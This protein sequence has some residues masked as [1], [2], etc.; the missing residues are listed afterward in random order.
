MTGSELAR[1]LRLPSPTVNRLLSGHVTDP[2]TST[3]VQIAD[4][5]GITVG[6]LIGKEELVEAD[7][8]MSQPSM[9]IPLFT[10]ENNIL[11]A[12]QTKT[13]AWHT[14]LAVQY[15]Q[16]FAVELCHGKFSPLFPQGTILI[17]DPDAQCHDSDY[18]LLNMGKSHHVTLK[19]YII[20]GDDVY[21]YPIKKG[22]KILQP[23]AS[24]YLLHGV[25][26]EAHINFKAL[27]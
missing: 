23:D 20:D 27:S 19:E 25:V 8:S 21:F 15:P 6:Q 18:V 13:F 16:V 12:H 7:V 17:V 9:Q 3:L 22:L 5:F 11:S 2:R 14:E 4:Y 10:H 26:L 1:R 24:D